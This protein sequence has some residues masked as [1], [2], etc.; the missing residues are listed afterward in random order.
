[1]FLFRERAGRSEE[2]DSQEELFGEKK[3]REGGVGCMTEKTKKIILS[4]FY[5]F[6]FGFLQ[7]NTCFSKQQD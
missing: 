7:Q 1:V 5:P 6:F 2:G 3:G 4:N